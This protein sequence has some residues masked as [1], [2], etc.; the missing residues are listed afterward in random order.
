MNVTIVSFWQAFLIR[1]VDS[2]MSHCG[3]LH[4]RNSTIDDSIRKSSRSLRRKSSSFV[5]CIAH[6]CGGAFQGISL[7]PLDWLGS[8][9]ADSM[10]CSSVAFILL[11]VV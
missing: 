1:N 7:R 2:G 10:G 6:P 9:P 11:R 5:C 3:V 8:N 4:I